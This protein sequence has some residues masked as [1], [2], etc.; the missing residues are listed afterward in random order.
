MLSVY[1]TTY[2]LQ[3]ILTEFFLFLFNP[4]ICHQQLYMT[5]TLNNIYEYPQSVGAWSL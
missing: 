2:M 4:N 3:K 1:C 5:F